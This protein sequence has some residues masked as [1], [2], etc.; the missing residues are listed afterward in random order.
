M[1]LLCGSA[2]ALT[3]VLLACLLLVIVA[4]PASADI[5]GFMG[6]TVSPATRPAPG[7][8]LGLGHLF[9]AF[10]FEY[11]RTTE[12]L[13]DRT[14]GLR[15]GMGN[16]LLQTPVAI[17]G[18]QPYFTTGAGMYQEQ[19]GASTETSFGFNTGGGAKVHL[20]GP[21]RARFDYRV[22]TLRGSPLADVVHRLY[23]GANLAF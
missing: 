2:R 8:A 14:P 7:V 18:I 19:L 10:E 21:L 6:A 12:D 22:F 1:D 13:E 4:G 11:A 3:R 20:A 23:V 9:F 17:A 16:L 15:T 5:T